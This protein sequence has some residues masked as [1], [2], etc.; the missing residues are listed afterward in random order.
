MKKFF[1]V[2]MISFFCFVVVFSAG[3]YIFLNSLSGGNDPN[4]PVEA[5]GDLPDKDEPVN[6]LILGVDAKDVKNSQGARSDTIMLAT[7]DPKSKKVN[8]ISIPRDT[9]VVIRGH[10]GMDKINHAHAYGGP[11]LSIKAVKDLLG[12][13]VHYY[14]RIDYKALG[15]IV[16]DLGGVEVDVPMN[17]KYTDPTADP[18]LRIDLKKGLQVLDGDKAMQ[19][20]RYRKGYADQDLGRIKAQQTFMRALADKLLE[21]QTI[22]KLPKIAKTFSSYVATDMPVSTITA[23][24]LKANGVSMENI[25]MMTIPGEPKL[26][27]GVWYYIPDMNKIQAAMAGMSQ[28]T[29]DNKQPVN[30]IEDLREFKSD[31]TIEVLNGSGISGLATDV[32]NKLKAEG[33]NIVNVD[34]VKGIKYNQTHI[35][36][37]KNKMTEAKKI[38]KL[39]NVKEVEKDIYLEAEAD[40]TIIVG[41]D[42]KK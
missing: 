19:F 17:M 15:K 11:D 23:Y 10:K 1:K 21:P 14:V 2:L 42:Y 40:V 7:F 39:L 41:S 18:P 9:K 32:S 6:V 30:K 31:V 12:V 13:P 33:Y 29:I 20:V 8:V 35:Y 28:E 24:A 5:G 16:D 4:N 3:A 27:S 38:A 36:D 25:Q 37:R 22:I 26:I 34:T